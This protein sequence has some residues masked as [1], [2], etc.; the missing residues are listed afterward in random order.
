MEK[1]VAVFFLQ[2]RNDTKNKIDSGCG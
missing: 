1:I 2:R